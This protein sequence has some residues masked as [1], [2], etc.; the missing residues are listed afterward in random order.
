MVIF[1]V[2]KSGDWSDTGNITDQGR[3][4]DKEGNLVNW[5]DEETGVR[6]VKKA[7]CM[8]EQYSGYSYPELGNITVNGVNTLGENIADNGGLMTSYRAYGETLTV[9]L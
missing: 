2:I 4:F 6:Y 5:W 1:C 7:S 8:V 3:R 9:V